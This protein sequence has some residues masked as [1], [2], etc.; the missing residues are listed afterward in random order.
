MT[1]LDHD[2]K[3]GF[4]I[5]PNISRDEV[6]EIT[7]EKLHSD[8]CTVGV[9]VTVLGKNKRNKGWVFVVKVCENGRLTKKGIMIDYAPT[10]DIV[11]PKT[12]LTPFVEENIVD[13]IRF[14][15]TRTNGFPP[16]I[17]FVIGRPIVIELV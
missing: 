7:V 4:P 11:G 5:D 16:R 17:V 1:E 3:S 9:C 12:F 10:I 2:K 8:S 14:I 15:L 13:L 6:G